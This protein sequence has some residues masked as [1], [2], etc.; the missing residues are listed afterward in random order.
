M[1]LF[2]SGVQVSQMISRSFS[3]F[4]RWKSMK[5]VVDDSPLSALELFLFRLKRTVSWELFHPLANDLRKAGFYR[6]FALVGMVPYE[7]SHHS[8]YLALF[9][10]AGLTSAV[11]EKHDCV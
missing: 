7:L 4:D 5:Q 10:L 6:S 3:Q 2:T 1:T 8:M 11:Q 9:S